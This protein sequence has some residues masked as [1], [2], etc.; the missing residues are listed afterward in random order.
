V[1]VTEHIAALRAEGPLLARAAERAGPDAPVPPCP[2]WRIRDLVRHVGNVH[3]WATGYIVEQ[4]AAPVGELTEDEMVRS[5]PAGD[6][7]LPG[8]FLDGHQ[9]LVSALA[10]AD[11]GM[12][13]WTFLAAPSPLAFWA[14]RQAHETAIHRVDA[15]LA[16]GTGPAGLD[17]FAPGLARDGIDELIMGFG[18]RRSKRG[19]RSDPPR[20]LAVHARP[21]PGHRGDGGETGGHADWAVR[22]GTDSAGVAR[23]VIPGDDVPDG[24]GCDLTGP[25]DAL[26][27]LLWNRGGTEG[28]EIS[29]DPRGLGVWRE[30]VSVRWS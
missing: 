17:P 15:Q 1:Q 12:T 13:C 26:Y 6:K 5:G 7:D 29:G 2:G 30:Q 20:W 14:R 23:G 3:R 18:R 10:Q 19:L 22:M 9:R 28:L 21:S 4:H 8:W 11:P 25:A 27:L 24:T 16:E